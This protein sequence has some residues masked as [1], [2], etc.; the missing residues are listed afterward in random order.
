[1]AG[2]RRGWW[3]L[4]TAVL[5]GAAAAQSSA[6][7]WLR[8]PSG[9][10]L[11]AAWPAKAMAEG[12]EGQVVLGCVVNIR[13]GL[14]RC[15]VV[16]ESPAGEGFG[17]AALLLVPSFQ[18]KPE[19]KD[20]QPVASEVQIPIVF[21]MPDGGFV[22]MGDTFKMIPN[23]A[24]SRAPSFADVAAV[25][26]KDAQDIEQGHVSMRCRFR[27]DGTLTACDTLTE[28]PRGKGFAAAARKLVP[29]FAIEVDQTDPKALRDTY[30]NLQVRLINPTAPQAIQRV[31]TQPTWVRI[32]DPKKVQA[33]YPTAAIDAGVTTGVGVAICTVGKDGSLLDCAVA[34][35]DPPGLGFG[36]AAVAVAGVMRMSPWTQDGGPVDG[37]TIR[38]PVRFNQAPVTPAAGGGN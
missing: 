13:G 24:W 35:E 11:R 1:M 2:R 7:D 9:A 3:L 6:P 17:A 29:L 22:P 14:E 16:S 31:L 33:V 25:W 38:L 23:P 4:L 8:K 5:A 37:S 27:S 20:G 28:S 12:V 30:V 32:P 36:A 34:S 19:V 26:P 10:E 18:L 21:K 15:A